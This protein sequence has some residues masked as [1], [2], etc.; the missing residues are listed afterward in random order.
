MGKQQVLKGSPMP[1]EK[2]SE[3]LSLTVTPTVRSEIEAIKKAEDRSISW[4]VL[5]LMERGLEAYKKDGILKPPRSTKL[6]RAG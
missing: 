6:R 3:N 1:T 5:A 4:I 2:R